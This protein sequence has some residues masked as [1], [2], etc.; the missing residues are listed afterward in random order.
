[1]VETSLGLVNTLLPVLIIVAVAYFIF[2]NSQKLFYQG[3]AKNWV[4]HTRDGEM[5]N[6]GI[7]LGTWL[8]PGDN[9]IE[10]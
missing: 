3:N 5:L 6:K 10:F 9:I 1:M 4:I 8:R 7:G 2:V